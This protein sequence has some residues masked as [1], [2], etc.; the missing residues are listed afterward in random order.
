MFLIQT[1]RLK[2]KMAILPQMIY[3]LNTI[4]IKITTA[5]FLEM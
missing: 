5:F 4:S 3:R 2:I 1:V